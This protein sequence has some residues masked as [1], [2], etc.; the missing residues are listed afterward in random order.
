MG[1]LLGLTLY[2]HEY[3]PQPTALPD[4]LV[5]TFCM[6]HVVVWAVVGIMDRYALKERLIERM[7]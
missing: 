6:V 7:N 4:T 5:A 3:N 1:S 2:E